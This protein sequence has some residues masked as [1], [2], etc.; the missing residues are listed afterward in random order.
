MIGCKVDYNFTKTAPPPFLH[1]SFYEK[2]SPHQ[3]VQAC[4]FKKV[5]AKSRGFKI[6]LLDV[7]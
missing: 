1:S 5:T 2:Y 3:T 7:L 4:Q 6:F